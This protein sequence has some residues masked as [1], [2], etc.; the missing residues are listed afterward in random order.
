MAAHHLKT[1]DELL[2]ECDVETFRSSGKGGQNVNRRE[3]AVRLTHKP[4]GVSVICQD[5]R[6][7][8]RN[9]ML[10][11]DELRQRL[12]RLNRR[13]KPRIATKATR[14]SRERKLTEKKIQGQ[15]KVQRRKPVPGE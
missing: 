1:D 13:R 7:Q 12:E 2:A 6:F 8:F 3:T 9:K 10:A 15:K 14:A 11:L 5:E 4:T